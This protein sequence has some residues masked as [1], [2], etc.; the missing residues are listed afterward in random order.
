MN[1]ISH[2]NIPQMIHSGMKLQRDK[3]LNLIK[4]MPP[5]DVSTEK[6]PNYDTVE[7]SDDAQ[8]F[9]A[10]SE[11]AAELASRNAT[12]KPQIESM[13]APRSKTIALETLKSAIANI[14]AALKKADELHLSFGERREFLKGEGRK[15]VDNLK[16]NDPEMFVSWLKLSKHI[17][18]SGH[19]E[20]ASLPRNFTMQDYYMYVKE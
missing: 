3:N 18:E 5:T 17:I 11:S 16:Q 4:N 2:T 10:I 6:K 1:I 13:S 14:E 20:N 9:L 19:P 7:L 12:E 8:S 15:W